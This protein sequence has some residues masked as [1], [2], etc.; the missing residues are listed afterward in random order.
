M[1][2]PLLWYL[3]SAAAVAVATLVGVVWLVRTGRS[4]FIWWIVTPGVLGVVALLIVAFVWVG[5]HLTG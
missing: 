4:Q 5:N 1:P 2:D 3:I